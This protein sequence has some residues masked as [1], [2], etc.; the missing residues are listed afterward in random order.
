MIKLMFAL[1]ITR[2]GP[3]WNDTVIKV[4]VNGT[5]QN[6][7]LPVLTV[8]EDNKICTVITGPIWYNSEIGF[9]PEK[10]KKIEIKGFKCA[11]RDII[12][13]IEIKYQG[14]VYKFRDKNYVP[15]W[16]KRPRRRRYR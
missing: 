6:S 10:G 2:W 8:K 1:L 4:K 12:K 7:T 5:I 9:N 15:L 3:C 14:K 16:L 13:A 11:D